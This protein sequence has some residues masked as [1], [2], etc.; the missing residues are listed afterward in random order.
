MITDPRNTP[1]IV[2]AVRTPIGKFNKSLKS[3]SAP[4]LGSIVIKE[5]LEKLNI[6]KNSIDEVIMGQ[7][8]QAGSGQAPARQS[9]L[10]AG[11]PDSISAFTVNKVC[12]SGLKAVM[13]AAQAIKAGDGQIIIAGGQESMTNTPYYLPKARFG[14]FYGNGELIDGLEY[15]GL[16][17]PYNKILMGHTGEIIAEK[18]NVSR[19]QADEFTLRSHKLAINAQTS[20]LFKQEI[21]PLMCKGKKKSKL[22][23][24][25]DGPRENTNL[26][27]LA[28]LKPAFK[29]D[30][31]VTAGNASSLNDG[32]SALLI[33]S[34]EVANE[35]NYEPL[36]TIRSYNTVGVK[37]EYVMEAPIIGVRHL[38]ERENLNI[39]NIDLVEHN[40]AFAT[41][42]VAVKKELNIPDDIFNVNGGA[43]ALGHPLGCSGARILTTLVHELNRRDGQ[44][45]IATVCLGGGN[46]VTMLVER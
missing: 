31:V 7:V 2:A 46:A 43:V 41:A 42:S 14:Y 22:V 35:L 44:L 40:E 27:K 26:E 33:M 34:K 28:K 3:F 15:D 5:L 1:V 29:K 36:A 11:L 13:L 10:Y 23:D 17:D 19:E 21:V 24:N 37:P 16:L 4:V 6:D 12:G 30:G 38:L 45:G 39:D 18:Y 20:G 25:D 8:L 32:A 9:A